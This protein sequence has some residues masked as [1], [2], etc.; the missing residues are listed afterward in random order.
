MARRRA[1]RGLS[2]CHPH[3]HWEVGARPEA[4][5]SRIDRHP[6]PKVLEPRRYRCMD[7]QHG[8]WQ[9]KR[10]KES[11]V[12]VD[13]QTHK[14]CQRRLRR[15]KF[16]PSKVPMLR[17]GISATRAPPP[18]ADLPPRRIY[19]SRV[20]GCPAIQDQRPC[21]LDSG[22]PPVE[23]TVALVTAEDRAKLDRLDA[24][25]RAAHQQF[26]DRV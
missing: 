15:A 2:R 5:L 4:S 26:R 23:P 9:G 1:G 24:A 17:L 11:R 19:R 8:H 21:R 16:L 14:T 25:K 7:A 6:W 22:Y 18:A 3:D 20:L 12:S 13:A 10:D